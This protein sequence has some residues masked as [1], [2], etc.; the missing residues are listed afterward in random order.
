MSKHLEYF[1][2]FTLAPS[3]LLLMFYFFF[4]TKGSSI[5]TSR[6]FE[7]FLTTPPPLSHFLILRPLYCRPS[8]TPPLWPWHHL[9]TTPNLGVDSK[10][11]GCLN[12]TEVWLYTVSK[13]D[14]ILQCSVC[15]TLKLKETIWLFLNHSCP[16]LKWT[17]FFEAAGAV[18]KIGLSPKPNRH[19]Q[20]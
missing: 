1:V 10:D 2:L 9:W 18:S 3:S 11:L 17:S 8:P 13:N 6:N 12:H 19:F 15:H 4:F 20:F 16:L 5:F 7:Q 14:S